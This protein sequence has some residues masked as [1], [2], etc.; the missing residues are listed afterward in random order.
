MSTVHRV[1]DNMKTIFE[2]NFQTYETILNYYK[3]K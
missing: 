3:F 2:N 1:L